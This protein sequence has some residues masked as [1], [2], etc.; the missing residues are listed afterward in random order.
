[1]TTR[2][3]TVADT[4]LDTPQELIDALEVPGRPGI[5]HWWTT[6]AHK[7]E[8]RKNFASV[9]KHVPLAG[10]T[11]LGPV[12]SDDLVWAA[13]ALAVSGALDKSGRIFITSVGERSGDLI[14]QLFAPD[15]DRIRQGGIAGYRSVGRFF[16]EFVLEVRLGELD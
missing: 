10:I 16:G 11:S 9:S 7:Q 15:Q 6:A 8:A 12:T 3:Y 5:S 1:M 14:V 2:L 13:K 4:H